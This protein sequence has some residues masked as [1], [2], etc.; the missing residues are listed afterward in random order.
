LDQNTEEDFYFLNHDITP[1]STT[2]GAPHG[3]LIT[4]FESIWDYEET[5]KTEID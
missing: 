3:D 2:A 1:L 5:E 4:I